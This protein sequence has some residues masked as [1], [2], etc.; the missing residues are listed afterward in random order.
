MGV[1]KVSHPETT[2][3]VYKHFDLT[4]NRTT[5]A[6]IEIQSTNHYHGFTKSNSQGYEYKFQIPFMVSVGNE[7]VEKVC[8]MGMQHQHTGFFPISFVF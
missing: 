4:G 5:A 6:W 2:F 7:P 8:V 3:Q 1:P